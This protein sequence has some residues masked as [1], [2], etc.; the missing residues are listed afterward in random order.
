M[1]K[2][3]VCVKDTVSELF[4]D[5]RCEVNTAS[6]IRSFTA[7]LQDSPHK[8]DYQL[9]LVGYQNQN[10]GLIE[11]CDP[12]RIYSGHDVKIKTNNLTNIEE[13]TI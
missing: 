2:A 5:I 6:A 11:P 8:D 4:L 1:K 13:N 9:Y 10:N 12:V 7:S 3:M